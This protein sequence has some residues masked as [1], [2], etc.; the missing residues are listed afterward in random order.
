MSTF[1][2]IGFFFVA[3]KASITIDSTETL[4]TPSSP[5]PLTPIITSV[6]SRAGAAEAVTIDG[7]HLPAFT[8]A[9]GTSSNG[10]KKSPPL[11]PIAGTTQAAQISFKPRGP[12]AQPLKS[13]Y[14][15]YDPAKQTVTPISTSDLGVPLL[16]GKE[17]SGGAG[18][19]KGEQKLTNEDAIAQGSEDVQPLD[20]TQADLLVEQEIATELQRLGKPGTPLFEG[21]DNQNL[22]HECSICQA[23]IVGYTEIV[24]HFHTHTIGENYVCHFCDKRK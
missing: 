21:A 1:V 2:L 18:G 9:A 16:V 22:E 15:L 4:I 23:K 13:V 17:Q 6:T 19:A 24:K 10:V 8:Q 7:G 5:P 14:L 11:K 12:N 20:D 3:E